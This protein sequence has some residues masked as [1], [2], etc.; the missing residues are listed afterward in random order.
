M[1]HHGEVGRDGL[2]RWQAEKNEKKLEITYGLQRSTGRIKM[3]RERKKYNHFR[4][5]LIQGN[6]IEIKSFE[7]L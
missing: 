2:L 4:N 7:Y 3:G 5:F 1:G 6:G